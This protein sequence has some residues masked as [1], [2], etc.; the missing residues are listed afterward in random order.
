MKTIA[1]SLLKGLLVI[2]VFTGVSVLLSIAGVRTISTA[3]AANNGNTF[4]DKIVPVKQKALNSTYKINEY[5]IKRGYEVISVRR[6]DKNDNWTATV[7]SPAGKYLNV[8]VNTKANK[9]LSQTD[10]AL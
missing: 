5:L 6:L 3:N 8:L 9:I 7:I 10:V 1:S 2:L 4:I